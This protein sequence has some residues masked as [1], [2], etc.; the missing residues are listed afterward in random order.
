MIS[1][2]LTML[3]TGSAFP[4]QSY[5]SC[6]LLQSGKDTLLA[7]GGGGMEI[8]HRLDQAGMSPASLHHMFVSHVHTDHIFGAVWVIRR[9]LQL[10]L[11]NSYEGTFQVLGNAEVTAAIQTICR[12]TLLPAYTERMQSVISLTTVSPGDTARIGSISLQFIDACSRGCTQTGFVATLPDG[13]TFGFLGDESLTGRN[14]QQVSGID[15]L[16]CGAYCSY[17]D[18]DIFH[19]YEKHHH[20]VR[21]VAREAA[22]AGVGCL[23]LCHCEDRDPESRPLLYAT[24]AS[25][26]FRGPVM[27]PADMEVIELTDGRQNSLV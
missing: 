15:Y 1:N 14:L 26:F 24:E 19:P 4:T 3:G 7:D 8:L 12:L 23:I 22:E 9:V 20:T 18:R 10:S 25:E 16:V 27:T 17:A 2:R 6:F 5:H 13:V 21:D 11:E